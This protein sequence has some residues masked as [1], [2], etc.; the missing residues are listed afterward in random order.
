MLFYRDK[1]MGGG[2]IAYKYYFTGINL[3]GGTDLI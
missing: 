2:Q 1:S 3:H